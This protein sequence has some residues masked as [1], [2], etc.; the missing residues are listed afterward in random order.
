MAPFEIAFTLG[1]RA[2]LAPHV[3]PWAPGLAASVGF[4]LGV[5][6]LAA[7]HN[8]WLFALLVFPPVV[9]WRFLRLL[10][11]VLRHPAEAVVVAVD[12]R[13]L[14]WR[15][16]EGTRRF[17]LVAVVQVY[18]T[19]AAWTVLFADNA[20]V[21]IP[22]AALTADQLAHLKGFAWRAADRRGGR[23]VARPE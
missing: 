8:P 7:A 20:A 18:R 12:D 6:Q 23:P 19:G 16:A 17:P 5:V 4:T 9:C 1:R 10:A 3:L 11:R 14:E 2:R 22:A 15:T 13:W 21:A